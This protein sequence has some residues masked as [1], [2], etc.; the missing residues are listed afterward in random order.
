M[1]MYL[2]HKTPEIKSKSA[3]L[4][5]EKDPKIGMSDLKKTLVPEHIFLKKLY[6]TF[7]NQASC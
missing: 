2:N 7:R 4:D 6:K 3:G 1:S 5:S